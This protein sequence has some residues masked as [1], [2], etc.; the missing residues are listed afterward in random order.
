M[1]IAGIVLAGGQSSRFGKPK[2]FEKHEGKYFYEHSV[3]ALKGLSPIIISTNSELAPYFTIQK[4]VIIIEDQQN[5]Q[6]PLFTICHI[7]KK[8]KH[9][10]WFFIL[11]SDVPFIT[12]EFVQH[13]VSFT[14]HNI[15]EAIIPDEEGRLH[16]LL[17][18]Y[19]RRCLPHMEA[20]LL[21]DKKS[22]KAFLNEVH[23]QVIPFTKNKLFTNINNQ[24]DWIR[25]GWV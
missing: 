12:S 6:G 25:S 4:D 18:L 15:V 23:V 16:P 3:K 8:M 14:A 10:D 5:F 21:Q 17:A 2:M 19:H 24:E 1:T 22:M 9:I 7:F 13:L 20:I 11:T